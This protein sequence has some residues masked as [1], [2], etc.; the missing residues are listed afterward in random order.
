[1]A[2]LALK[3]R[4]NKHQ[5]MRIVLFIGSPVEAE[6]SELVSVGKKLRK[7]NVAVDVVSFGD[8]DENA[9]KLEA[10][11]GAVNKNNNSNLV[12][13]PPGANLADVL[14]STPI[15]MDEDS[16]GGSGFAAAAAAASSH[17]AMQGFDGGD[18]MDGGDD[19]ALMLALRVSLEEERARQEAAAAAANGG[20]A[21]GDASAAPAEAEAKTPAAEAPAAGAASEDVSMMDEDALLQRAF[22]LSM[23]GEGGDAVMDGGEDDP[24]LQA[25]LAM[26]MQEDQAGGAG[27]ADPLADANYV[28]SI[29][30]SLPGVDPNDPSIQQALQGDADTKEDE[31][32]EEK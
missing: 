21:E 19:P 12:T 2:H 7:C 23:G 15:F 14:L 28:N 10:F 1:V 11:M 5:R 18:M 27:A 9:E 13:V 26:S 25:A 3:H 8:V 30:S 20:D 4:Q 32:E 17:A 22:A 16:G 24:A 29:L 6:T 31:G